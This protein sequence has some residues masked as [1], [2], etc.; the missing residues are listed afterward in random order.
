MS[1]VQTVQKF[2]LPLNLVRSSFD[3]RINY[4]F[5]ALSRTDRRPAITFANQENFF[6]FL[7]KK[8]F[9]S[10]RNDFLETVRYQIL[11]PIN[12]IQ[13]RAIKNKADLLGNKGNE[14]G[15]EGKDS[16]VFYWEL[17]QLKC[18][19]INTN[20]QKRTEKVFQLYNR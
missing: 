11:V 15:E 13:V 4:V 16:N 10:H 5:M 9:Q 12:E 17:I 8:K 7:P 19:L 6:L 1:R 14:A 18:S 3:L 2:E 20:T